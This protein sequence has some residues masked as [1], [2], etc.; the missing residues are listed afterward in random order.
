[1]KI[2][3]TVIDLRTHSPLP[4]IP[5]TQP[6]RRHGSPLHMLYSPKVSGEAGAAPPSRDIAMSPKAL[7]E[8]VLRGEQGDASAHDS[9][10]PLSIDESSQTRVPIHDKSHHQSVKL[11]TA[12]A[13]N[14]AALDQTYHQ[15]S[16]D[17][18][19][20]TSSDSSCSTGDSDGPPLPATRGRRMRTRPHKRPRVSQ[21]PP[22]LASS[23]HSQ[24]LLSADHTTRALHAFLTREREGSEDVLTIKVPLVTVLKYLAL[25]RAQSNNPAVQV[26]S[27]FN[28]DTRSAKET[29][30]GTRHSRDEDDLLIELKRNSSPKPSWAQITK[31]FA[32]TLPERRKGSLQVHYSTCLKIK[33]DTP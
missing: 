31:Q 4:P 3:I 30:S 32:E 1:M 26:I 22:E 33:Q 18:G 17:D 12:R 16:P 11:A 6:S 9:V 25:S 2:A 19:I 10:A 5:T 29:Q 23:P 27:N 15:S 8:P 28:R 13:R 21:V 14:S 7:P 24:P 20:S